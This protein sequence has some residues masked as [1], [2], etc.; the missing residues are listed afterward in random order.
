MSIIIRNKN[1]FSK[2]DKMLNDLH[3]FMQNVNLEQCGRL[4]VEA[5][6]EATPKDTGET[7]KSWGY[8]ISYDGKTKTWTITWTNSKKTKQGDCIALLIQYGHATNNGGYVKGR[9]YINPALQP[10]FDRIS[11]L[12]WREVNKT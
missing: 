1:D 9:D 5:L 11:E 7:S 10:I 12:A 8:Q 6:E 2:T 4:G 3:D